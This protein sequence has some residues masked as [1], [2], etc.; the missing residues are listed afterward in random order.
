MTTLIR[1][2]SVALAIAGAVAVGVAW[3]ALATTTGLI[4]HLMPAG[5]TLAAAWVDRRAD[6]RPL[7]RGRRLAVL[8]AGTLIAVTAS[9]ILAAAGRPLDEPVV[10][11]LAIVAGVVGGGWI[12]RP[13][14]SGQVQTE[15]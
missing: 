5:P 4:F 7:S 1:E 9:L 3:Y 13:D 15:T 10:T 2:H 11:T 14:R 12:L 6:R 8:A